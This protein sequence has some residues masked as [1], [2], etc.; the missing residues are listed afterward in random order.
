MLSIV[1]PVHGVRFYLEE[2][3]GS[4][5]GPARVVAVD[6]ASPDGCGDLLDARAAAD[7][8]LTVLHHERALG[9]GPSRNDGLALATGEYVWFVDGDDV[10]PPGAIEAVTARLEALRPDVLLIGYEDLWPDGRTS[11]A[12]GGALLAAAPEGLFTLADHPA[13]VDLTMTGWSKVFRRDFLTGLREPFRAGVHEDVPVTC[14]ALLAG[15]LA[16]LARPVYRYRRSR[17]GSYL[18]TTSAAHLAIFSSYDEVFKNLENHIGGKGSRGAD[19]L[20]AAFFTRAISHYCSVLSATGPGSRLLGRSGLVPRRQR[21][22]FF[23]RMHDDYERYRPAGYRRPGGA[24]GAKFALV[25]R[26]AYWLYELL[27]PLSQL[28][29]AGRNSRR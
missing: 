2:C 21:H 16:A 22:E 19:E 25:E 10:L 9:P 1:V 29:L 11:P 7:A 18:A 28:R 6:D 14:A 13:M 27:E 23:R 3:L 15:R 24:R 8:R 17:P 5:T 12:A 20:R 26:D 4:L